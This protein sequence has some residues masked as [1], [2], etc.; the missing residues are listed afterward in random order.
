MRIFIFVLLLAGSLPTHAQEL[1]RGIVV[2]S[3][4][5]SALPYV[6]VQ[7]KN[8]TRGTMTDDKGNFSIVATGQ[9]TLVFT[10]VGYQRLDFPLIGYEPSMIRLTEKYTLLEA[11]TINELKIGR[12]HV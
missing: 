11:V 8:Q 1:I 3:A 6:N 2:D 10:L 9:D 4:S 12:A 5:F 7:V